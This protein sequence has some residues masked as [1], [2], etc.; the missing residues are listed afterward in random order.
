VVPG[1][2]TV[3]GDVASAR[4]CFAFYVHE[5]G[6]PKLA[7]VGEYLDELRRDQGRWVLGRRVVSFG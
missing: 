5:E 1:R 6:S 2:I 4:S 3:E 7:I